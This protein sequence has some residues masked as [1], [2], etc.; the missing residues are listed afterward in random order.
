MRAAPSFNM[1]TKEIPRWELEG[2]RVTHRTE[3]AV[4]PFGYNHLEKALR[5]P[6]FEIYSSEGLKG[7]LGPLK[8]AFYRMS[9]TVRGT[10]DMQIGLEQFTHQPMTLSF[11]YPNQ[12]F[13][14]SNISAD[15]FGYY[16]LF[17]E[18]FL[19]PLVPPVRIPFEFPF[20]DPGGQ[21]LFQVDK[22]EMDAIVSHALQID[23]E[24]QQARSGR[25]KAVQMHLYLMLLEAK[26]SYE[27]QHLHPVYD[28]QD[29]GAMVRRFR[30][31]IAQKYLELRQ[32]SG[33]ADLLNVTP[34]HLNRVV[35]QVT[36]ET[37]SR[38]IQEMLLEEAKNLLKYT[39]QTVAEIAYKL[40]F[41]DP[42]TFGRFFKKT[43][44]GQTPLEYRAAQA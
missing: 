12:I 24:L 1:D 14:K 26:R 36:G 44:G 25:V 35:K 43:S 18:N 8:S 23:R 29:A 28:A 41:G 20:F 37:A 19:S 16:A 7:N 11:T 3:E 27:R 9:I 38:M 4:T 15:A 21:P 10:L 33:Y 2:F 32:V 40:D 39:N 34:N 30:K 5:I 42:G 6:G 17:E 22:V 31:L 13:S